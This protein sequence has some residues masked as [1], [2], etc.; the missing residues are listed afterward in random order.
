AG[1]VPRECARPAARA[2]R[3]RR[4]VRGRARRHAAPLGPAPRRGPGGAARRGGAVRRVRG[5][6][7]L[8][9]L[10]LRPRRLHGPDASEN[11]GRFGNTP[12]VPLHDPAA[13]LVALAA[14][15]V[16]EGVAVR[17]MGVDPGLTRCGVGVVEG[18]P[19]RRLHLV[20]V[21]VVR[22]DPDDDVALRL[23]VTAALA[24]LGVCSAS[25]A[26]AAVTGSGRADKAQVT[27]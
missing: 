23:P 8:P 13:G 6:A 1:A 16:I 19:G 26:K 21:S 2:A 3:A 17:V 7:V 10:L 4:P 9:R 27:R 24:S 5:H 12:A 15:Q 22:T 25:E 14:E 20:H 11:P 18:A